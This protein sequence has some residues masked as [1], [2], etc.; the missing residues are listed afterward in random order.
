MRPVTFLS[1]A[2]CL[3]A[4]LFAQ[5]YM[6]SRFPTVQRHL[7]QVPETRPEIRASDGER[8][9][10]RAA[11]RVLPLDVLSERQTE[12]ERLR[13]R[14]TKGELEALQL[15]A[16]SPAVREHLLRQLDTMQALLK[17]IEREQS[18]QGKSPAALRVQ[19]HLNEIE[20]RVNCQACHS[21]V[22]AANR[23]RRK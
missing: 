20:G 18:D 15:S 13:A 12:L 17:Y 23:S 21:P 22:I 1:V 16:T 10:M 11:I 7:S 2:F 5:S 4:V 3:T 14:V 9:V 8:M 6:P 19:Q